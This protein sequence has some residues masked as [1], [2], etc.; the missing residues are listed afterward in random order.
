M[1]KTPI[2]PD[3]VYKQFAHGFESWD[4]FPRVTDQQSG[5]S[6]VQK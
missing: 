3:I 6:S 2:K 1:R 4:V 5:K